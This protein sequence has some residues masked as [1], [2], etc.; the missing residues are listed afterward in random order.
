MF[1]IMD[2][3]SYLTSDYFLKT[4]NARFSPI[5]EHLFVVFLIIAW[6]LPPSRH[7]FGFRNSL[8]VK[9]MNNVNKAHFKGEFPLKKERAIP[10]CW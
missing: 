9:L 5:F 2:R 1:A 6:N 3:F 7:L 8:P 10:I 4:K